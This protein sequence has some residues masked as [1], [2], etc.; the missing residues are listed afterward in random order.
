VLLDTG[1]ADMLDLMRALTTSA[2]TARVV[3]LA[4]PERASE[5]IACAEAGASGYVTEDT[6]LADLVLT[7]QAVARGELRCS[8]QIAGTLFR[9]VAALAADSRAL[10]PAPMLTAREFEVLSLLDDGLS[11]KQ[12]AHRLCI[13]LATVKNHVHHILGKLQV[14]RRGEATAYLRRYLRFGDAGL[15]LITHSTVG[16]HQRHRH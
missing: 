8:P 11:N 15:T 6:S 2:P 14:N 4:L 9:R 5:V 12:I 7:I 10:L 1:A 3:A 16:S 13:E